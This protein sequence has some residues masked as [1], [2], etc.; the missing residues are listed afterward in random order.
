MTR[1]CQV[2]QISD[3]QTI[4]NIQRTAAYA[5]I[6]TVYEA[7]EP[8][9]VVKIGAAYRIPRMGFDT[10]LNEG[11]IQ[12]KPAVYD[13][14]QLQDILEIRRTAAYGL[15][16]RAYETQSPFRVLK[17]GSLYRIPRASFDK[18][19]N[20]GKEEKVEPPAIMWYDNTVHLHGGSEEQ[21]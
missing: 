3:I 2:Y 21:T 15:A 17:I 19:L 13:I 8:F 9:K 20:G 18:W 4:L 1:Q 12:E 14:K 10:W 11:P 16:A 6:K 7:K 5:F